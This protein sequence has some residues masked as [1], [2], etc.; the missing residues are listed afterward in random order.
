MRRSVYV[1]VAVVAVVTV[2]WVA[3]YPQSADADPAK[4]SAEAK[5]SAN[6]ESES[7]DTIDPMG[8]NSACYVCH[9]T[10]VHEP[11]AKVHKEAK[12]GCIECHGVSAAHANDEHIGATRPDIVYKHDQVDPSCSKCHKTH[13][14]P[15]AKV[16]ARFAR[17][18]LPLDKA[19]IC[20]DCHGQHR[21]DRAAKGN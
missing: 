14:V 19:P 18:K 10:F 15:A 6:A 12:I 3:R 8:P 7:S 5:P 2:A 4:A 21:I 17:R 9:M 13:D 11:I 1:A 20:T 16:V